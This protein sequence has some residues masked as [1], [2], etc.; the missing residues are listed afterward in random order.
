MHQLNKVGTPPW[1]FYSRIIGRKHISKIA[2][3]LFDKTVW[4]WRRVDAL[5]PWKGLSL[6]AIARRPG[7]QKG[8][9]LGERRAESGVTRG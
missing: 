5:L 8:A 6:I 7:E 9:V 1:W 2:L 3:K 4:I